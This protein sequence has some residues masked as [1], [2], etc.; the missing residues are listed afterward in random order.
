MV[1]PYLIGILFLCQWE[2]KIVKIIFC[3]MLDNGLD[4][5][6]TLYMCLHSGVMGKI[7]TSVLSEKGGVFQD[8][9]VFGKEAKPDGAVI[10]CFS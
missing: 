10:G 4:R 1:F 5:K 6:R 9:S 7:E 2:N 3:T 8:S